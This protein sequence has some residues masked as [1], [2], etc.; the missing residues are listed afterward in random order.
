[1]ATDIDYYTPLKTIVSYMMDANSKS[2]GD[3]DQAWLLGLRAL[4]DLNYE[5]SVHEA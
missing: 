5:I 1:M 3:Q 2:E 4:T